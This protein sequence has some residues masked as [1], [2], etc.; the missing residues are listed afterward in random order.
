MA[1]KL[2]IVCLIY[3]STKYLQFVYDQVRQFTD[4]SDAEFFFVT[5]D[6]EPPVVNY[7]TAHQIPHYIFN[8]TSAHVQAHGK[9]E[10]YVNNVYRAYN[11]GASKAQGKYLLMINS[12]MAFSKGWVDNMFRHFGDSGKDEQMC[13]TSRLIES[14]RYLSG[15]HGLSYD[16]GKFLRTY[17]QAK[18]QAKAAAISQPTLIP[19]GL[20]MP[21]LIKKSVFDKVGGFPEGNLTKD[22][23]DIF[24]P[25]IAKKGVP[26][27]PGDLVFMQKL[28][29]IGVHHYTAFDSI[30]YHFQNGEMFE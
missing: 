2:S 29:T 3:K 24:N 21:L 26:S 6:A 4:L 23:T 8:N 20:Y 10:S 7:L 30:V 28:E 27:V 1:P 25:T 17:N 11:Y 9:T 18:F 22:C 13:I 19:K 12:D 16:C 15:T 14:G 5:N